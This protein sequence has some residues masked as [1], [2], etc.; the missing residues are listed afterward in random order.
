MRSENGKQGTGTVRH[1]LPPLTSRFSVLGHAG[2][3]DLAVGRARG[4]APGPTTYWI[5][6]DVTISPAT[7]ATLLATAPE[8]TAA[9]PDVTPALA[10]SLPAGPLSAGSALDALFVAGDYRTT[11]YLTA[12][13]TKIVLLAPGHETAGSRWRRAGVGGRGW[14]GL[15]RSGV[16]S[17]GRVPRRG[18]GG[19][20]RRGPRHR[21]R[22]GGRVGR[23]R[24]WRRRPRPA[25]RSAGHL[26]RQGFP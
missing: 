18:R 13:G 3:G 8:P 25:R 19:R 5:D 4:S 24:R 7:A 10:A 17:P 2:G 9:A 22:A 16:P 14:G 21:R 15:R 26:A 20:S 1:D 23:R 6:A 11:A 12:D